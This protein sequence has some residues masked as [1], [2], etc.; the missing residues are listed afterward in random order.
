MA[1]YVAAQMMGIVLAQ[2]LLNVAD[3]GG[4]DLFIIMSVMVS[5]SFLPILLSSSP[6]PMFEATRRMSLKRLFRDFAAWFGR[7]VPTGYRL[8]LSLSAC[9]RSMPRIRG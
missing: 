8:C 5:L 7:H 4:Y 2:A 9:R 6:V 1:A 3:P